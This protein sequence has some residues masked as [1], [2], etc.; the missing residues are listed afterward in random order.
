MF[1]NT[2]ILVCEPRCVFIMFDTLLS[3]IVFDHA[4]KSDYWS[5]SSWIENKR[6]KLFNK[7]KS[8]PYLC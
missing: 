6:Q 1:I 5:C 3:F 4:D 7:G 2:F 8:Y